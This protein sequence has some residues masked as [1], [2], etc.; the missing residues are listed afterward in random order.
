MELTEVT[1]VLVPHNQSGE[2]EP[3]SY[4][5]LQQQ[6]HPHLVVLMVPVLPI[7]GQKPLATDPLYSPVTALSL[8]LGTRLC[9]LS[10]L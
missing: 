7:Q 4:L 9:L 10:S 5:G 6:A 1:K 3:H 8:A 2:A